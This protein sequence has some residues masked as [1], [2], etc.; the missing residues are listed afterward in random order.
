MLAAGGRPPIPEPAEP[1]ERQVFCVK[2]Q[3]EMPGLSEV[4]FE[5]NPLGQRIY[6]NVS[7]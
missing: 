5:G 1:G 6:E 7:K 3:R 2:F 4:S